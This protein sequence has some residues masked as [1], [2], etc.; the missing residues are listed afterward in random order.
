METE[1]SLAHTGERG[2][3]RTCVACAAAVTNG[4]PGTLS[5]AL[6]KVSETVDPAYLGSILTRCFLSLQLLQQFFC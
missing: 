4:A 2:R 3:A 1:Q 5:R 6:I